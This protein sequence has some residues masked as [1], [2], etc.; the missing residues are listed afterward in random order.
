MAV[1]INTIEELQLIG[2][3]IGASVTST[4]NGSD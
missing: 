1:L 4:W 3:G 2:N